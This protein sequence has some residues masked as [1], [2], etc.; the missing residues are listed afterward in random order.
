MEIARLRKITVI[1]QTI[2]RPKPSKY[3]FED[4][5]AR[6]VQHE[7]CHLQGKL[8]TDMSASCRRNLRIDQDGQQTLFDE[9]VHAEEH[10]FETP[11]VD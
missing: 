10:G 4:M 6:I 1:A 3:K 5:A 8:I 11:E 2:H 7:I 9:N